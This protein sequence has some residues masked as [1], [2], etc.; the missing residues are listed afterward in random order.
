MDVTEQH[1]KYISILIL[2]YFG[3]KIFYGLIDKI[4]LKKNDEM[5]D[6]IIMI[7][8]GLLLII[9]TNNLNITILFFVGFFIGLNIPMLLSNINI[10]SIYGINY[11]FYSIIILSL[12]GI[13]LINLLNGN[14]IYYG[15]YI[16]SICIILFGIIYTRKTSKLYST[17]QYDNIT[18]NIKKGSAKLAGTDINISYAF[19]GWLI[20]LLFI[21][22]T[23]KI[24]LINIVINL[25]NGL[26]VGLF[27]GGTSLF[28]FPYIL[29]NT[30][31]ENNDKN[32]LNILD[33]EYNN[34]SSTIT[35]LKWMNIGTIILIIS[36]IIAFYIMTLEKK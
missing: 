12:I 11:V 21:N 27:V 10:H 31:Q 8:M 19:I 9:I 28:G 14:P 23:S 1:K 30:K 4:P 16:V 24:E 15:L 33:K 18:Q 5:K 22:N 29:D 25:L 13:I 32:I 7:V 26:F 36:I 35:T 2:G 34:I 17:T 3:I 6:F 20:S